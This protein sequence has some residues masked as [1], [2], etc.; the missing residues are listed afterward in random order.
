MTSKRTF[1]WMILGLTLSLPAL[2]HDTWLLARPS[3][4]QPGT[5]VTLELT[6]GMAY[7]APETAIK[8]E[9]VSRAAVRLAGS[10]SDLED[11]RSAAK[12]LRLTAKP[13]SPGIATLWVE[14]APKSIDLTPAQVQHYLDE[15]GASAALRQAWT[16]MP[17]PRRW[18]E[19]YTKHT[20]AYVRVGLPA[21]DRSWAEPVGMS[22]E[23][24]PEK[25]PTALRPGEVL[26]VRL[27][28]NGAPVAGFAVGLVG[29]GSAHGILKTTDAEGRATFP[30]G[31][32]GR[33]L[34]RT[35]HVRRSTKPEADW[36]SN[37]TT[38]TFEVAKP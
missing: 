32:A 2:A 23:L 24:V 33:W 37:F 38:V 16:E 10:T 19:L 28:R 17:E 22:L 11:R 35:T 12:F 4:V 8:P 36:E 6:S 30:I 34:L 13:A 31:R 20:K 21:E 5:A 1:S 26:P 18:R 9:R 14:L 3:A 15:I 7:P 25:D 29:P 27:L